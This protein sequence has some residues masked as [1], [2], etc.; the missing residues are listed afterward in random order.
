[1]RAR[2]SSARW[3][4]A[5]KSGWSPTVQPWP[6]A[7][8]YSQDSSSALYS[9]RRAS[10]SD[11]ASSLSCFGVSAPESLNLSGQASPMARS[12]RPATAGRGRSS[13]EIGSSASSRCP[14]KL[15]IATCRVLLQA[16]PRVGARRRRAPVTPWAVGLW[17]CRRAH[18]GPLAGHLQAAR[19]EDVAQQAWAVGHDAVNAEVE[20]L[21]H[22]RLGVHGP[23]MDGEACAMG[24][25][26]EAGGDDR[27]PSAAR[28]D[29]RN[30]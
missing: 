10:R 13:R 25:A 17:R 9:A 18:A 14:P 27:D 16:P 12:E 20:Q 15:W 7:N 30:Q 11:I 22:R 23:D 4:T 3:R 28:R 1:M 19:R 21:M 24:G 6:I 8:A 2:R 5:R 26:D 29:A